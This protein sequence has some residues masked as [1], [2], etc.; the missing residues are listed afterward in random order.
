MV[1]KFVI[2]D[3]HG[4]IKA[5]KQVFKNSS[6]DF[7]NDLLIQL[8]DVVDR[9]NKP[10]E[11][12][13]FLNKVK[14]K[15]LIRGNHD[16]VF[17]DYLITGH[18]GFVG[19]SCSQMTIDAYRNKSAEW[20]R[21]LKFNTEKKKLTDF[22]ES[23]VFYYI[24]EEKR[25]FVH[26]GFN[27]DYLIADQHPSTL[28]WDR[29]LWEEAYRLGDKKLETLD[30]FKEIYVGHTPTIS[31]YE[32]EVKTPGGLFVSGSKPITTP[33]NKGQIFWNMDTGAGVGGKLTM[34]NID[35]KEIFQSDL[36]KIE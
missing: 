4:R 20:V 12:I 34:M 22:F 8:G 35:T 3:I 24:D 32:E 10:F 26:G 9:G 13:K 19:H 28:E 29:Y 1:R 14:N 6:F 27:K 16:T 21:D 25:C 30:D 23:Q 15:I 5:L 7:K 33:M 31:Y 11:C 36:L 18:H 2:G 17:Y